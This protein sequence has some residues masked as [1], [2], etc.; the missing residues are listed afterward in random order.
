M[1]EFRPPSPKP[2][3]D[4][5]LLS[6]IVADRFVISGTL[7][8]GGMGEVYEATDIKLQRTVALKRLTPH[9]RAN[10]DSRRKFQEEAVRVSRFSDPHIAS[11]YD[12]V[13]HQDEIFLVLEYVEGQTLRSRLHQEITLEQFLEIATQCA[14]ALIAAH[15][16]GVI[17]CDIKPEN[18]MLT[19]SGRVKILDFGLAQHLPRTDQSMTLDASGSMAGT[20][21]Y[22]CPEVL[23]ERTPDAR[24]DIFSLGVV[25]YEML[26]RRHPFLSGS[27]VETSERVLR[28]TPKPVRSLNPKVPQALEAVVSKAVAKDPNQRYADAQ[29]LLDDIRKSCRDDP[30]RSSPVSS[31]H[32]MKRWLLAFVAAGAVAAAVFAVKRSARSTPILHE[33]GWVLISDFDTRGDDPIPDTGVREG[34]TIALQQSQ[35]VN[36]YP[37]TRAYEVLQ[38]M[39]DPGVTRID[40]TLGREICQRENVQVLLTGSIEHIGRVFQITV[41]AVDPAQ[42][43]LLFAADERFDE[44]DQFFEKADQL[45][46]RVRKNL[47]E[48]LARIDKTSRPLAKVTSRSLPALQ[49]YSE[50]VD[51]MAR[52]AMNSVPAALQGALQLDPDFAMAHFQ[53]GRYYSWIVGKNENASREL[54]RA[55]DL[56]RGVT[57]REQLRIESEFYTDQ[58][59]YDDAAQSLRVLVSLYPDD[60]DAHEDLAVSYRNLAQLEPAIAELREVLR[61]NPMSASAYQRL[62]LYLANNNHDDEAVA[63]FHQAQQL[64]ITSAELHRALGLAYLGQDKVEMA[65]EEFQR[66]GQATET[67]KDL[68]DLYLIAADL[69]EGRLKLGESHLLAQIRSAPID[70]GGLLTVRR[71]LLGRIYL[72]QDEPNKSAE[73]ADLILRTPGER[74]QVA[75]VLAAGVIYARAGQV[76][77]ARQV[78]LRLDESRKGLP[79]SWRDS[80]FENLQGEIMLAEKKPDRAEK[81]FMAALRAYPDPFSHAGLARTYEAQ[82]RWDVASPEWEK[83]L[84][85]KGETLEHQF[86]PDFLLAHLEVA[87][88]YRAMKNSDR[89]R[90]HYREFLRLWE[91]GDKIPL[92]RQAQRELDQSNSGVQITTRWGP[93]FRA[94]VK[95]SLC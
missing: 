82:K 16:H 39:R 90:S 5:E 32:N 36:V 37:R 50:A 55:Y 81:A 62:V 23:L 78:L 42:G 72:L 52:G 85:G 31:G 91:H 13:E 87:R 83:A 41:R 46:K 51:A 49:L 92:M 21:A 18:I 24:S 86:P 93:G 75:D 77:R 57:N 56:R 64:G 12:V 60:A 76:D 4:A 70:A 6:G 11:V 88:A 26:T 38:R 3:Q 10:P 48:S 65:R 15:G 66:I 68:R 54:K 45:S 7:G 69:Y 53:L 58:E 44:K 67:D 22:M 71:Y 80:C 40:E 61:L 19:S 29:T 28:E 35:Y 9:L 73:Q 17:H 2:G 14:E 34:L 63:A 27:F 1:T 74:L 59:R 43:N 79:S 89:A 47:G 30:A 25:F 95:H 33:R 8:K 94:A 20:P 84:A